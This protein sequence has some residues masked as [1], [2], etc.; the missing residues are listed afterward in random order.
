MRSNE[1]DPSMKRK[2]SVPDPKMMENNSELGLVTTGEAYG[3]WMVI[4]RRSKRKKVGNRNGKETFSAKN[5]IGSRF[6]VLSFSILETT[7]IEAEHGELRGIRFQQGDFLK[8]LKEKNLVEKVGS[9]ASSTMR[10]GSLGYGRE[11]RL[12]V[13]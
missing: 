10:K 1:P 11:I 13:G 7:E 3:P 4:E 5:M 6:G 12:E 2:V 8:K 9:V